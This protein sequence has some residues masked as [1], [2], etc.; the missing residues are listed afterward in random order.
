MLKLLT[1]SMHPIHLDSNYYVINMIMSTTEITTLHA[2]YSY[3][4]FNGTYLN[5][6]LYVLGLI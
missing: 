1:P 4:L 5:Q 2:R 3:S 6:F